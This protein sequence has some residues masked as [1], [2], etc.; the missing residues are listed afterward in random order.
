MTSGESIGLCHICKTQYNLPTACPECKS[1][2]IK[3]FG[4][5]IQKLSQYIEENFKI[6]PS[7][8]DSEQAR[9]SNKIARLQAEFGQ[10]QV[11]LGTSLLSTPPAGVKI[12]LL[13]FLQAD[14]GLNIPDYTA[15]ENNFHFLYDAF[16]NYQETN[17]IVQTFNPDHYSIRSAC[18]MN[19]DLFWETENIFRVEHN[20]PPA[21]DL[22]IL[23][24]KNEIEASL[25]T[26]VDSLYK[27]LLYLQQKYKLENELEIYST[28]PLI[29]KMY[30]KYR[31]HIILK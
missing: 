4:L 12:D 1:L 15:N 11:F 8:V 18:K 23:L 9:S 2:Q 14:F 3:E 31:Y 20:Y 6:K 19:P 13:V 22:C 25:F 29:Y 24:Y 27:E 5:G 30:G 16:T 17:F 7:I 26:K 10:Q 21:G 28:P